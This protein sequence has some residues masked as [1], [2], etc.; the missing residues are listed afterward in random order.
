M[1]ELKAKELQDVCKKLKVKTSKASKAVSSGRIWQTGLLNETQN[2]SADSAKCQIS[3]VTPTIR[4]AL[5][6]I[7][8]LSCFAG[9]WKKDLSLLEDFTSMDLLTYLIESYI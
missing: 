7:G 6:Q 9:D 5:E 1:L 8:K 3:V 2:Q 4:D